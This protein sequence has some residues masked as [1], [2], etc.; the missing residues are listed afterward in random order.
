MTIMLQILTFI[1]VA[2]ARVAKQATAVVRHVFVLYC[3]GKLEIT[4]AS[5]DAMVDELSS[6][7]KPEHFRVNFHC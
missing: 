7:Y 6:G 5:W 2:G 3:F 1:F 4:V